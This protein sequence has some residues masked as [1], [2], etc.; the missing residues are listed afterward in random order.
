MTPFRAAIAVLVATSTTVAVAA[1]TSS[2]GADAPIDWAQLAR[3]R[4]ATEQFHDVDAAEDAGYE[5]LDV[6]F[7]S[8]AGGMGYHYLKGVDATLDPMAPEA[9]V[10]A[11]T[12][13]GLQLVGVEYIVPKALSAEAPTVLGQMLHANDALGL[14]VL[15]AW[16]WRGNPAGVLADFNPRVPAC[17]QPED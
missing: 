7:S 2:A 16:I 15:H 3:V 5:L 9:L 17:P 14:W 8:P 10:Y 1:I 12:D 11:P 6:C 4:A 13:H